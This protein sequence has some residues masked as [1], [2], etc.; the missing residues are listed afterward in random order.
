MRILAI[1]A[2]EYYHRSLKEALEPHHQLRLAATVRAAKLAL[3]EF[4]PEAVITELLLPD[5]TGYDFLESLFNRSGANNLLTIVF[6]R[7]DNLE[8]IAAVLALGVNHYLV[9]GRDRVAD[10]NNLLLT[11]QTNAL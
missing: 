8:D 2:D 9:K 10:L 4:E 1:D 5:Q 6:T 7:I 3:Q 11:L